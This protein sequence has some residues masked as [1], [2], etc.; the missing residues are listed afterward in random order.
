MGTLSKLD[1]TKFI[2]TEYPQAFFF[3]CQALPSHISL[4]CLPLPGFWKPNSL[5]KLCSVSVSR[6]SEGALSGG[7]SV[8]MSSFLEVVHINI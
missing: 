3:P 2:S 4:I 8:P 7:L 6:L 5:Q 1:H